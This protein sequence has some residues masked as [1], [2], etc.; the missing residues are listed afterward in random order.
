MPV[1]QE[2]KRAVVVVPMGDLPQFAAFKVYAEDLISCFFPAD[3][4]DGLFI[5]RP[6]G[7][8]GIAVEAFAQFKALAA[9][10]IMHYQALSVRLE[11]GPFH[12]LPYEVASAR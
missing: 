11:A 12:A 2:S 7:S 5:G 6:A 3:K 1:R 10:E 8:D 4:I 9:V